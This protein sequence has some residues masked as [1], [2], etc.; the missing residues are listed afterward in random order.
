MMRSTTV[1]TAAVTTATAV[2]TFLLL[3]SMNVADAF[4]TTATG[5]TSASIHRPQ[6][7]GVFL[8]RLNAVEDLTS[9]L[10]ESATGTSVVSVPSIGSIDA[11]T[12]ASIDPLILGGVAV[13]I[14]GA[15]A[16]MSGVKGASF[17]SSSTS[18]KSSSSSSS[19]SKA[20]L[21]PEPE[22]IDVSI[23]YNAAALLA[24][25]QRVDPQGK[26]SDADFVDFLA[27]Y[28]EMAV[29]EVIVKQKQQKVKLLQEAFA[30]K[31]PT[32]AIMNGQVN[33]VNGVVT[34]TTTTTETLV[35][36]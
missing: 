1:G 17:N 23:P 8:F 14:L 22:P 12:S 2:A 24:Y 4:M 26:E 28:K 21:E 5:L 10:V 3:C 33:G 6:E 7:R 27:L 15:A 31:Y 18:T 19:S 32:T 20:I 30:A 29:A 13:L 25:Q 11:F 9:K 36:A 35:E 16:V 34:K